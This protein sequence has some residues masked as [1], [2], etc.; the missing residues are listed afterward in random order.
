R[1]DQTDGVTPLIVTWQVTN[2]TG[3]PLVQYELDP[4]GARTFDPPR[5]SFDDVQTTYPTAGLWFPTLRA[6]NDQGTIYTATT[7]VLA[8]DPAAVTA[9]FQSVWSGFK[10]RLQAGD[11]PGALAFVAPALRPRLQS[12]FQQLGAALPAIAAGF[13]NL[14]V[15]DQADDLAETVV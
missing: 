12:V 15:T 13:G 8:N 5:T 4:T 9:G 7:V 2:Q 11:I 1:A 3:R 10:A 14:H 6:T